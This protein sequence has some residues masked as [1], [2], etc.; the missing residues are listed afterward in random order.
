MILLQVSSRFFFLVEKDVT[1]IRHKSERIYCWSLLCGQTD[2][3]SSIYPS[4]QTDLDRFGIIE[5]IK[6][7]KLPIRRSTHL[8]RENE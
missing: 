3:R 5:G 1:L 6:D 4:R 2:I 8:R 7:E